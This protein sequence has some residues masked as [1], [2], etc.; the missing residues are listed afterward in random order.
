ML[1]DYEKYKYE[2]SDEDLKFGRNR[3][4]FSRAIYKN[5]DKIIIVFPDYP[6]AHKHL[7]LIFIYD[8]NADKYLFDLTDK[9][10]NEYLI[11]VLLKYNFGAS[12]IGQLK[13]YNSVQEIISY[14]Y[15]EKKEY[16][17][18]GQ[19]LHKNSILY[20]ITAIEGFSLESKP[21][22]CIMIDED[23]LI[24]RIKKGVK[25]F[26]KIGHFE[27]TSVNYIYL[28]HDKKSN[29]FKIG[30]SKDPKYREKTLRPEEPNISLYSQW[31]TS[32]KYESI[33]KKKFEE[34]RKR[35]EWFQLTKKDLTEIDKI[36]SKFSDTPGNALGK[37]LSKLINNWGKES[38]AKNQQA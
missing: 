9:R 17:S 12:R 2:S 37:S 25:K 1:N 14:Y 23:I 10:Y 11:D 29:L 28:M 6:K 32:Q 13:L 21:I 35:G 20:S 15:K 4:I 7:A 22:R 5:D 31:F 24:D 8:D 16:K 19:E 18:F 30:F 26:N 33:L 38:Q 34:K 27:P 3:K 36:M